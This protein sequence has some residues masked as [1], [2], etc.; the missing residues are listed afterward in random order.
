VQAPEITFETTLTANNLKQIEAN[1]QQSTGPSQPSQPSQPNQ[2]EQPRGVPGQTKPSR[3]LQVDEFVIEGGKIHVSIKGLQG[4]EASV[5]LPPIILTNLGAGPEGITPAELT[6]VVLQAIVHDTEQAAG[7]AA[8]GLGKGAIN[9]G[10]NTVG[11]ATSAI[12]GLFKKKET[13]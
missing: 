9:L 11:K 3:K 13:P 10:S 5:P 1:V 12:G 6:K 4:H 7:G 2:P 8:T